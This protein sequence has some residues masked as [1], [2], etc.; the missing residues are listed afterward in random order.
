MEVARE[1]KYFAF[2]YGLEL[3]INFS[4][5]L[6]RDFN[7]DISP[8]KGVLRMAVEYKTLTFPN[9]AQ[10]QAE[11]IKALQWY[12]SQGWEVVSENIT[13]GKF[14][15]GTAFCLAVLICLPAAFCAGSTDGEI[16]VTLKRDTSRLPS[17]ETA[18]EVITVVAT[19]VVSQSEKSAPIAPTVPQLQ[20]QT[21]VNLSKSNVSESVKKNSYEPVIGITTDALIKR[22]MLFIED[23]E[24]YE[25][26][27]YIEQALNQDPENPQV[28]MAKLMLEHRVKS[29][30]ELLSK[31]STPIENEKLFQRALRFADGEYKSQLEGL[32]QA[33]RNKLEQERLAKEAEIERRR[34]E[35][36]AEEE[37]LYQKV[38]KLKQTASTVSDFEQL[39]KLINSIRPYKNT[40]ELYVEVVQAKSTEEEYQ[41]AI[42]LHKQEAKKIDEIQAVINR[43]EKLKGYKDV[44]ELLSDAREK[45]TEA[46]KEEKRKHKKVIVGVI[47]SIALIFG[48]TFWYQMYSA[49]QEEQR[50]QREAEARREAQRKA[51]AQR[52]EARERQ[53]RANEAFRLARELELIGGYTKARQYY[54]Q[55]VELGHPEAQKYLT[56]LEDKLA[57]QERQAEAQRR[58]EAQRQA[59]ASDYAKGEEYLNAKNYSP[60]FEIFKRLANDGYAPAQDK[61]AWMYQNGWGVEQN[62]T[63]AVSWFRK[64][65]EQ[66]NTEAITSMGLMYIKGWGVPQDY[67]LSLEWYSR[68]AAKGSEVAKRRVNS[69][70]LLR[71]NKQKI[72]LIERNG[73][74]P[75]HGTI[76]AETLSIRPSP[77]TKSRAI[78]TLKTGHP[79]SVSRATEA[80]NDYWLYITT[81]SGMQGWVLAGYVSINENRELSN[82]ERNN[83]RYSLP[84][85][86]YVDIYEDYLNI[87]DIP[88]LKGSKVVEKLNSGTPITVYDVFAGDTIDWYKVRTNYGIEGWVS[89]KYISIR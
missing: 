24:I 43:L 87:R 13:Q 25:A 77:D 1:C 52:Q 63:Q 21:S 67:D 10:G 6:L 32:A 20:Q 88:T 74:Y 48:G 34:A 41:Y 29:P 65:A 51:E 44:D 53:Q 3:R 73:D 75:V 9:N 62:Y 17:R 59:Y 18:R 16:T 14:R 42:I 80:D 4:V 85:Q 8:D 15:G 5:F 64:A 22:V 81:A 26:E 40:D 72:A 66:G 69:I 71:E 82:N 38:L 83:R 79:V 28:Y 2:R 84:A 49:K 46:E 50:I 55:A 45:L 76:F 12:S 57:Q 33:S 56:A 31:L 68:A 54:R 19:P 60:A 78:K 11:K 47:V 58:A 39:I 61:L 70:L 36:E 30:V 37:K 27:R 86:G 35:K 7:K 23:G 89:G